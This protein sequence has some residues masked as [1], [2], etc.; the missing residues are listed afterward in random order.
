MNACNLPPGERHNSSKS[1][2]V[3]SPQ[4]GAGRPRTRPDYAV[5]DKGYS[6]PLCRTLLRRSIPHTIPVLTPG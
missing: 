5:A 4:T 1:G 6:Y 3:L 2:S